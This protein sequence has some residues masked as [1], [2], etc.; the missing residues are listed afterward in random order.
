M[1]VNPHA[2]FFVE[3]VDVGAVARASPQ[4]LVSRH[5]ISVPDCST[6]LDPRR[7]A[8]R[9]RGQSP[10]RRWQLSREHGRKR[11]GL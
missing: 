4:E 7:H 3:D 8:G 10:L 6:V 1:R 2:L 5:Q 9:H 11:G